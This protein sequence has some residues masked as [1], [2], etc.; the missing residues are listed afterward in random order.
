MWQAFI[1]PLDPLGTGT[2]QIFFAI[3]GKDELQIIIDGSFTDRCERV[4]GKLIIQNN[5]IQQVTTPDPL[6]GW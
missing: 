4:D 5:N 6:K 1:D 2:A 3:S